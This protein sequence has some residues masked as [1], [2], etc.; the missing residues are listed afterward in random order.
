MIPEQQARQFDAL[1]RR[2]QAGLAQTGRG[3]ACH[4]LGN[5]THG[6]AHRAGS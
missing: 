3:M 5:V 4:V 2:A 6:L 1:A